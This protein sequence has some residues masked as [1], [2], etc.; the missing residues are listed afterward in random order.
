M[1]SIDPIHPSY[2][3]ENPSMLHWL[4]E[5]EETRRKQTENTAGATGAQAYRAHTVHPDNPMPWAMDR[6]NYILMYAR[7]C[8][9]LGQYDSAIKHYRDFFNYIRLYGTRLGSLTQVWATHLPV[10]YEMKWAL[11]RQ[12]QMQEAERAYNTFLEQVL[13]ELKKTRPAPIRDLITELQ[14][15]EK[16]P[17]AHEP[18]RPV[19]VRA[20]EQLAKQLVAQGE[21]DDAKLMLDFAQVRLGMEQMRIAEWEQTLAIRDK[22]K[23]KGPEPRILP[24]LIVPQWLPYAPTQGFV[25]FNPQ[26]FENAAPLDQLPLAPVDMVVQVENELHSNPDHS[27]QSGPQKP[28]KKRSKSGKNSR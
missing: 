22:F 4:A 23:P 26:L 12:G 21:P 14:Q 6:M 1:D 27:Q 19:D 5:Q 18:E 3:A 7:R 8:F 25:P 15:A 20:L 10:M 17:V 13:Q 11:M 9:W 2:G 24:R 16:L 28:G